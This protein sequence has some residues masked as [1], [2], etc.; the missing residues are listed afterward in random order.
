MQ[1]QPLGKTGENVSSL[2]LGAM[3]FG[4]RNDTAA[5]HRI[6]DAYLDAG[7]T[8]IDTANIYAHW[9]QGF[10]GGE[11]ETLLGEWMRQH[12]NRS[13][14]FIASKVGFEYHGVER[15]LTPRQIEDE[16]NKSLKRLGI[17]TI[18][19]YYAHVD[20]RNTPLEETMKAFDKLVKAGKVRL[21]GG[22]N[23]RAWRLE[24]AHWI[25]QVNNWAHFCCI[26]QHYTY[27][28]LRPGTTVSPQVMANEDLIDYCAN[29]GTTLL[30]YSV[31]QA[32]AYTRTDRSFASKFSSPDNDKRLSLLR[33]IASELGATINQIIL[34]WM[35]QS[36]PSVIPLIAASDE[37]Q[38]QE[39][40]GALQIQ[41]SAEQMQRLNNP[42]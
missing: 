14:L 24:Q 21:I 32:G 20:D 18:D 2:C 23:Y 3:Y 38:L 26:Q 8:F 13:K 10:H 4:T 27:L 9:I 19:L 36:S 35:L 33:E 31:L 30:A 16:C 11:S 37:T 40:L 15:G 25:S 29:S 42:I 7:G 34:R 39:N 22:S 12:G 41:L 6:L 17:D 28:P 1:T 5:S